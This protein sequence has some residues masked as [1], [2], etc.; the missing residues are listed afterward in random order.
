MHAEAVK[1]GLKP[2]KMGLRHDAGRLLRCEECDT[3]YHVYY[4][5]DIE[6]SLP[7]WRALAS[8]IITARHPVHSD[9]IDL[10][11]LEPF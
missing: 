3:D 10:N 4:D 8:E 11:L 9:N 6:D 7:H 1:V 2:T 5:I